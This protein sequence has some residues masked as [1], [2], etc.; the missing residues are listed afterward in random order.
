MPQARGHHVLHGD[1][2]LPVGLVDLRQTG[3][4]HPVGIGQRHLPFQRELLADEQL[5]KGA[6]AGTIG[7][8]HG[9]HVTGRD[10]QLQVVDGRVPVIADSDVLQGDQHGCGLAG[11]IRPPARGGSVAGFHGSMAGGLM[12]RRVRSRI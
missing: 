3:H 11:G 5:E 6:L 12:G 8:D 10:L 1:G 7:A 2:K 4:A 9:Q